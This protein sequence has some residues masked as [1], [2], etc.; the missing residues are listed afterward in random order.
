M[1]DAIP[2]LLVTVKLIM[3]GLRVEHGVPANGAVNA[4]G[5]NRVSVYTKCAY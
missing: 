2:C 5:S 1:D 3:E 4:F